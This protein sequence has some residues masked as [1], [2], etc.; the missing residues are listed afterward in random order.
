MGEEAKLLGFIY[1]RNSDTLTIKPVKLDV[2]A[3]TKRTCLQSLANNWDGLNMYAPV[4][5][6][7]RLFLQKLQNDRNL[8]R[9]SNIGDELCHEWQ[10]IA[11]QV[12]KTPQLYIKRFVGQQEDSYNLIAYCDASISCMGVV[13]YIQNLKTGNCNYLISRS[14]LIPKAHESKS[15]PAKE[16]GAICLAVNLVT[17]L[18]IELTGPKVVMP[19][20]IAQIILFT[21]SMVNLNWLNSYGIK[22]EKLQHKLSVYVM[23]RLAEIAKLC[24]VHPIIF[25]FTRGECNFSDVLTRPT[26]H[27]KLVEVGYLTGPSELPSSSDLSITLPSNLEGEGE[28]VSSS[29]SAALVDSEAPSHLIP[30][31]KFSSFF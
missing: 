30:L 28:I 3:N 11:K 2:L 21:D 24:S 29:S 20:H 5:L 26:S 22:I 1:N 27:N 19:I 12:N 18:Y 17:N 6:R 14:K 9:D 7:A 16:C 31:N 15:I 8:G 25:D 23:N 10:L 13:V 4:L